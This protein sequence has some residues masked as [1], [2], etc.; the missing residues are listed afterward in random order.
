[1]KR[2]II[3]GFWEALGLTG[4]YVRMM[5]FKMDAQIVDILTFRR[6]NHFRLRQF[7]VYGIKLLLLYNHYFYCVPFV[8]RRHKINIK[9]EPVICHTFV[10][11]SYMRSAY[12]YSF[13]IY[14][15]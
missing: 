10:L 11:S 6:F 5:D 1:M 8:I 4:M 14:T 7:V 9:Y 13:L 2:A 15:H 12:S 3:T